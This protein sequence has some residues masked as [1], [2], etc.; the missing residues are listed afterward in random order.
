MVIKVNEF[1]FNHIDIEIVSVELNIYANARLTRSSFLSLLP[2]TPTL[3]LL[4]TRYSQ[5]K[6]ELHFSFSLSC[7]VFYI[8]FTKLLYNCSNLFQAVQKSDRT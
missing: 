1:K 2:Q 5:Y 4:R 8:L 6:V 3:S 7:A